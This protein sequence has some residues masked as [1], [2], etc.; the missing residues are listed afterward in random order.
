V[1]ERLRVPEI[2]DDEGQRLQR[3]GGDLAAGADGVAVDSG[4]GCARHSE[5]GLH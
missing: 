2:D 1:T 5:G 3:V 4:D